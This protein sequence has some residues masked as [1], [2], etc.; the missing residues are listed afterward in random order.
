MKSYLSLFKDAEILK[1]PR[2]DEAVAQASGRPKGSFMTIA[3]RQGGQEIQCRWLG[4]KYGL[5][6]QIVPE[7]LGEWIGGRDESKTR[8]VMLAILKMVKLDIATLRQAYLGEKK[9]KP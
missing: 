4:D 3:F 6:W 9:P 8:R 7:M 2:Y 5:A 1:V